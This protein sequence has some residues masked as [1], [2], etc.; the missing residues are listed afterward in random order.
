[1]SQPAGDPK[2]FSSD[3]GVLAVPPKPK[4][5]LYTATSV[6]SG[7]G[8][9]RDG[10]WVAVATTSFSPWETEFVQIEEVKK[11]TDKDCGPT[12]DQNCGASRIKLKQGLT[13]YHFG[14]DDPGDPKTDDNYKAGASKNYGVDERAEVGL[15]SRNI[16]LTSDSDERGT[17]KHWVGK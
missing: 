16:V 3:E 7:T 15:I 4:D 14:G 8:A 13:Y 10:N 12:K 5:I 17:S 6:D 9:W 2:K 11:N 1:L